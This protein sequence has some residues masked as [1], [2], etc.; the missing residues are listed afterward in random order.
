MVVTLL[1]LLM[2]LRAKVEMEEVSVVMVDG[3]QILT[4]FL[5]EAEVLTEMEDHPLLPTVFQV[6]TALVEA[7]LH[8]MALLLR[9]EM[10]SRR[11]LTALLARVDSEEDLPLH[12]ELPVK[13]EMEARSPQTPMELQV[14]L[15]MEDSLPLLMAALLA[16]VAKN[17][18]LFLEQQVKVVLVV[19]RRLHTYH[20]AR[21]G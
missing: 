18:H 7:L 16:L 21:V 2:G 8:P 5:T 11:L 3:L 10:V 20:L 13:A 4:V 19:S 12:T 1:H 9:V 14:N 17:P 6:K 15:A